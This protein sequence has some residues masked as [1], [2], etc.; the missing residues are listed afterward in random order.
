MNTVAHRR[1][2]TAFLAMIG[3]A[4]A[5]PAAGQMYSEGYKFLQAVKKK[6]GEEATSMLN[7]PGSTVINAR[8]LSS[9]ET[10]LH[11]TI[12]RRDLVWTRWLLQENANPNVASKSG[13]TPLV[14][15][16]QMNF[17]EGVEALV[18]GGADVDVANATGETPLI[19]AVHARNYELMEVLLRSGANPDRTD[20]SGRSARDYASERGAGARTLAVIEEFERPESERAEAN[21]IYGPSF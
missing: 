14:M 12:Q 21:R 3:L 4:L 9:G 2:I 5:T 15:A 20:N 11:Y 7:T 18:E 8:D 19:S 16:A 10:A 1:I 13:V 6:D 17:I